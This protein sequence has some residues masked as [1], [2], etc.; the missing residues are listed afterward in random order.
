MKISER[1]LSMSKEELFTECEELGK[2]LLN[3]KLPKALRKANQDHL[4][5]LL[6]FFE[7]RFPNQGI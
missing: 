6:D 4:N 3:K 7:K 2:S 1:Y 5:D